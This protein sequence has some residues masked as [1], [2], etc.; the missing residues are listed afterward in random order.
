MYSVNLSGALSDHLTPAFYD[1]TTDITSPICYPRNATNLNT[2]RL[3][4]TS[5]FHLINL[6]LHL[7]DLNYLQRWKT[8]K[9]KPT[10]NH[11]K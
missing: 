5:D 10:S 11:I 7:N 6:T 2:V 4:H 1:I 8:Q 3:Q 9:E